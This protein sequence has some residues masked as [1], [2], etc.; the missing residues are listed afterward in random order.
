MKKALF[1][2]FLLI[3]SAC[4][5]DVNPFFIRASDG[6]R[7]SVN[8]FPAESERGVI[9]LHMLNGDKNDWNDFIPELEAKRY[10]V[11]AIDMRGHGDSDLDWHD[12]ENKDEFAR[13]VLD[14]EAAKKY[15]QKKGVKNIG[16]IGASIGSS[17]ALKHASQSDDIRTIVLISPG[18]S[19]RGVNVVGDMERYG[20]DVYITATEGDVT[21]AIAAMK[22]ERLATGNKKISL[23]K[24]AGHGTE[25]LEYEEIRAEIIDWLGNT[26]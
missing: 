11:I 21:S 13:S 24:N 6:T 12:F 3:L 23:Y 4:S 25:M 22:L 8:Y 14:V 16:I 5:G 1:I 17:I 26:I 2:L 19:Y 9:L 10:H 20:R 18:L 15:L 7:I